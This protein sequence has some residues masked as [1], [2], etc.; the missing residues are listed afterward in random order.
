MHTGISDHCL[1]YAIRKIRVFQKAEDPVEIENMKNFNE[2]KFLNEL[3]TQHWEY[4][5][6]FGEN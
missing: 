5:Y 4:I 3:L 2:K 1:V 6:Y